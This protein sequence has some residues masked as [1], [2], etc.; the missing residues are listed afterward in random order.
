M[1]L[2][3][4]LE[5]LRPVPSSRNRQVESTKIPCPLKS[6]LFNRFCES[7][8]E[9]SEQ[10]RFETDSFVLLTSLSGV[11]RTSLTSES[12]IEPPTESPHEGISTS[13][14]FWKTAGGIVTIVT[15]GIVGLGIIIVIIVFC[16]KKRRSHARSG[17]TWYDPM[18]YIIDSELLDDE[19]SS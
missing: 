10:L 18:R 19:I 14:S 11:D 16:S 7:T 4:S 15:I 9:I 3:I 17:G 1:D 8:I 2:I 6:S 5:R 13:Q 12:W